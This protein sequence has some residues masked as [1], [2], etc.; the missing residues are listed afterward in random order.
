LS[1][2]VLARGIATAINEIAKKVEK[3]AFGTTLQAFDEN[4]L[5]T[6]DPEKVEP[7]VSSAIEC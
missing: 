2:R 3:I 1:D 5:T 6:R 4:S 7:H